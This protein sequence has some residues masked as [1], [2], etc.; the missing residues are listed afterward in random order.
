M[1]K[2]IST[3]LLLSLMLSQGMAQNNSGFKKLPNG[4]EY[5]MIKDVAGP[6]AKATD[7]SK[8]HV[9]YKV[10]DTVL[11]NSRTVSTGKP[12]AQPISE[13]K[14]LGDLME[15][16][17]LLSQGDHAIFRVSADSFFR[18]GQSRPPFIKVGAIAQWDIEMVELKN[19]AQIE[20]DKK[21]RAIKEAT[22]LKKYI[23]DNK[24]KGTNKTASGM[25]IQII[26][27]G[28]GETVGTG[29]IA[30]MK[31]TGYLLD[32]TAFDSNID[33][34]FK[35]TAP[36]EFTVGRGMVI[37][38]WDEG[39]ALLQVGS[40]AKLIIPS[41][42]A[43]GAQSRPGGQANPKGIPANSPLIFDVEVIGVKDTPPPPPPSVQEPH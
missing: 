16:F 17:M 10:S 23:K 20:E 32:G 21:A 15:G 7:I 33:P 2:Y 38:G 34:K 27:D 4:L 19:Q 35:H 22:L 42:L 41:S 39:I 36:F 5:K 3:T 18:A 29:R 28:N 43:Y 13:P 6:T 25:Y 14:V 26:E 8:I 12:V 11:F 24:L 37:K 40:K 31:Y 30:K 9:I 1:V